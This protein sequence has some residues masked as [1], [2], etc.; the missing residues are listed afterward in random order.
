MAETPAAPAVVKD[1]L[2]SVLDGIKAMFDTEVKTLRLGNEEL[3]KKQAELQKNLD[4]MAQRY[5]ERNLPGN[6]SVPGLDD[7][8]LRSKFSYLRSLTLIQQRVPLEQWK[9]HV[10]PDGS[11][12]G[13]EGECFIAARKNDT[14]L[15]SGKLGAQVRTNVYQTDTL[16]G[17]LVPP[18]ISTEMLGLL[19]ANLVVMALGAR[20]FTPTGVP[21]YMPKFVSGVATEWI[22]PNVAPSKSIPIFGQ[23]EMTPHK[24]GTHVKIARQLIDWSS[25]SAEAV[26]RAN[27]AQMMAEAVDIAALEG[28]GLLGQPMGLRTVLDAE[29][30]TPQKVTVAGA[31]GG[32]LTW[33]VVQDLIGK[34]ED[35]NALRGNLGFASRPDVRR[36]LWK[37]TAEM[38][39]GQAAGLGMPIFAPLLTHEEMERR[40]GSYPWKVST[41][42]STDR[43]KGGSGAT[44]ST[45]YFGNWSDLLIANFSS[46]R[47]EASDKTGDAS[48]SAMLQDLLW[49]VAFHSVDVGVL[50]NASFSYCPELTRT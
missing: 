11:N 8:K 49:I 6:G 40:E 10:F 38:Y 9:D 2:R 19:Y 13:F 39:S 48:G 21:W 34:V 35:G 27:M 12:A 42:I 29:A 41:L 22:G 31:N 26:I 45:A 37:Q 20:S 36:L 28:T 32:P 43:V 46:L 50:R 16:G 47:F 1:E 23:L 14:E 4:D 5:R 33:A 15:K 30:G 18:E 25:P 3:Q 24:V 44:L 17:Y 7:P